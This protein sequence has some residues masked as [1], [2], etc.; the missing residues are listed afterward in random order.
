MSEFLYKV[1][2]E[3]FHIQHIKKHISIYTK[4]THI[5]KKYILIGQSISIYSVKFSKIHLLFRLYFLFS[6][7]TKRHILFIYF[8]VM[9]FAYKCILLIDLKNLFIYFFSKTLWL[10]EINSACWWILYAL[11]FIVMQPNTKA[12]EP[13]I[14]QSTSINHIFLQDEKCIFNIPTEEVIRVTPGCALL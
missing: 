1:C 10:V 3:R 9:M 2:S 13:F 12:Y 8:C 4:L 5:F 6:P 14:N 7:R 11:S